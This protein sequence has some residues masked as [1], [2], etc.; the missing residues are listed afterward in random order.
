MSGAPNSLRE[1][2]RI[3]V[4]AEPGSVLAISVLH[5]DW[6]SHWMGTGRCNCSPEVVVRRGGPH[7]HLEVSA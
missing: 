7:D 3:V 5:D 6:C 1:V 2:M 4:A